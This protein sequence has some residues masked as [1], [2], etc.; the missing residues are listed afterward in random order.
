MSVPSEV[1]GLPVDDFRLPVNKTT[2]KP[3][4]HKKAQTRFFIYA[5]HRIL[6]STPSSGHLMTN[7]AEKPSN[8]EF[9]ARTRRTTSHVQATQPQ[10]YPVPQT[11][12]RPV[13]R[14][15]LQLTPVYT[16]DGIVKVVSTAQRSR[17]LW[18]AEEGHK[19]TCSPAARPSDCRHI[20]QYQGWEGKR[21][22]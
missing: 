10:S 17:E 20:G 12:M 19:K 1:W 6:L 8:S 3:H 9:F 4:L 13:P 5:L 21:Q 18:H 14:K 11:S 15:D 7:Q 2:G 22:T 16:H